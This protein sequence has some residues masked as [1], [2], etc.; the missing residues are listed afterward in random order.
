MTILVRW[1]RRDGSGDRWLL[2][3]VVGGAVG[4]GEDQVGEKF[5]EGAAGIL[6]IEIAGDAVEPAEIDEQRDF[7]PGFGGSGGEAD[8]AEHAGDMGGAFF[9]DGGD[10]RADAFVAAGPGAHGGFQSRELRVGA[11]VHEAGPAGGGFRGDHG[12]IEPV[13]FFSFPAVEHAAEKF[14]AILKVPV[15]AAF[16]DAEVP[17]EQFDA[18]GF[19]AFAGEAGERS[20]NPVVGL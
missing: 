18:N 8:G 20:S 1:A 3:G 13:D 15:E 7:G 10:A 17:G 2:G 9:L 11:V 12:F 6:K 19:N 16:A 5:V 4:G 14:F